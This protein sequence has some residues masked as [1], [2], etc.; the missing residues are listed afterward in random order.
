MPGRHKGGPCDSVV[1]SPW[2]EARVAPRPEARVG[3]VLVA[4]RD[5][6]T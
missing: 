3:A 5:G 4:A 6:R 2:L 1:R